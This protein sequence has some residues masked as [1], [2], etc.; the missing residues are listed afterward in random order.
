MLKRALLSVLAGL[1]A[2]PALAQAPTL[3]PAAPPASICGR[4]AAPV[5]PAPGTAGTLTQPQVEQYRSARD[6]FFADADR[7]LACLDQRIDAEVKA[8]FASGAQMGP[9]LRGMG[10]EHQ[11]LS[12]D[13]AAA[14][15]SFLRLCLAWED[16]RRTRLPGGCATGL[17]GSP[18]QN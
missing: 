15:E 11:A 14:H 13:R 18:T 16:A 7:S 4:P 8:L 17:Q 12:R 2:A 1:A 6:A 5:F 3:P 9:A 10:V